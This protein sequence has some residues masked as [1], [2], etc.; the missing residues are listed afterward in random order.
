M[1]ENNAINA[2]PP[3]D[4][5]SG[6]TGATTLTDH[7]VLVGSGT[8]AIT[9]L[10]VGATGELLVGATGAD[11]A[12][13]TS[14]DGDFTFTSATAS[15]DRTL[16]VSNTDNTVAAT[17]AANLQI[18]VGG[19]NVGDPRT[20]YT[21]TGAQSYTVGVDNDA[22][23][24][25]K[26]AASTALGTTDTFIMTTAGERT[27]PLQPAFLATLDADIANVTGAGA[28]F[29][30]GSGTAL[31]ELFDQNSDFDTNGTFTAPVTGKYYLQAHIRANDV[32]VL[33]TEGYISLQTSNNSFFVYTNPGAIVG[34]TSPGLLGFNVGVLCDMDASDT[35]TAHLVISNGAGDTVDVDAIATASIHSVYMCG[36]LVC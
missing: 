14:A 21:V 29:Q 20:T 26:I 3:F 2:S 24:S 18:T 10:T 15:V 36:N 8:A 13:G 30:L 22:S 34:G 35:A 32:S 7:G 17:S 27:M 9:A 11:P 25:F 16:T 5:A 12:F 4:V 19:G 6:G 1:P 33:M 23:D 28:D 31:T